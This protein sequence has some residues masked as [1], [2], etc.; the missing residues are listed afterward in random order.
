[1]RP[2]A[3]GNPSKTHDQGTKDSAG[4]RESGP[5]RSVVIVIGDND[6]GN[7]FLNLLRSI[8]Q[9]L[10]WNKGFPITES[11]VCE[12]VA[13]GIPY[14]YKAFQRSD[15]TPEEVAQTT[16]YLTKKLRVLFNTEAEAEYE[17]DHNHGA[18]ILY[19]GYGIVDSF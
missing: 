11:Q 14:F 16:L 4:V 1:M 12:W 8:D 5:L 3:K 18:W 7:T 6:Y 10:S 9:A 13:E 15:A 2:G 19:C 17:V